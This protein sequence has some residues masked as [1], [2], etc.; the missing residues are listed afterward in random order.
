MRTPLQDNYYLEKF[1]RAPQPPP[2]H[3]SYRHDCHGGGTQLFEGAHLTGGDTQFVASQANVAI[4]HFCG[5][6]HQ[7]SQQG[8]YVPKNGYFGAKMAVFGPIILNILRGSKSFG[9]HISENHQD[10]LFA[11]FFWSC[12]ELNGLERPIFCPT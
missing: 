1:T 7:M 3:Q 6:N 8:L 5:S 2:V 9:N 10:T 11:L 4:T 12:M